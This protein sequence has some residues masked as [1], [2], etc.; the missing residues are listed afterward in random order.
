MEKLAIFVAALSAAHAMHLFGEAAN[1]R[2]KLKRLSDAISNKKLK[3]YPMNIDTRTKAYGLGFGMPAVITAIFYGLFYWWSPSMNVL[4]T[5]ALVLIVVSEINT[6]ITLDK[7][8]I[9]IEQL[10]KKLTSK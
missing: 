3:P 10:I 5:L 7:Y 2:A 8:H 4:L 6:T 9:S 1:V